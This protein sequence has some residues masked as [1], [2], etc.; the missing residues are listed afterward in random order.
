MRKRH[1]S[2]GF[3]IVEAV[4]VLGIIAA[5]AGIT[6]PVT[7]SYLNAKKDQDAI[8]RASMLDVQKSRYL[9]EQG[10][11]ALTAWSAAGDDQSRYN[12]VRTYLVSPPVNLGVGTD[13]ASYS[14]QGYKITL[15]GLNDPCTVTKLSTNTAIY[16]NSGTG[17]SYLISLSPNSTTMGTVLGGGTYQANDQVTVQA[18]PFVGYSFLQW[19]EGSTVVSTDAS[20]TFTVTAARTLVANFGASSAGVYALTVLRNN[21]L[22]GTVSP[23]SGSYAS[24]SPVSLTANPN[25]SWAFASWSGDIG[26][27]N[28]SSASITLTMDHDRTVQANFVRTTVTLSL[29]VNNAAYG[30]VAGGGT[31]PAG[32]STTV[33]A[34]AFPGFAFVNWVDA[35]NN[36]VSVA[37]AYTLTV[38]ANTTLT[39]VFA[40][41]PATGVTPGT[42]GTAAA[43]PQFT[44]DAQGRLLG[45]QNTAINIPSSAVNGLGTMAS[46]NSNGVSVTGGSISGVN[47]SSAT[48]TGGTVTGATINATAV[49]S[50]NPSTGH[51]TSVTADGIAGT[52]NRVVAADTNGNLTRTTL[53]PAN[54]GGN[55]V[56][57]T[58]DT[59]S[60]SLT[61]TNGGKFI[62]DT[63]GAT[64]EYRDGSGN[65]K[66]QL[67]RNPDDSFNLYANGAGK[68]VFAYAPGTSTFNF[69]Q[70][71]GIGNGSADH[72]LTVSGDDIATDNGY[73]L[74]IRD[75]SGTARQALFWDSSNIA[76]L[77]NNA[78]GVGG[79]IEIDTMPGG[80]PSVAI[81]ANGN[82]GIGT[83]TPSLPL[84]VERNGGTG[85]VALFRSSSSVPAA[86]LGTYPSGKG[87]IQGL[88]AT[89]NYPDNLL[90]EPYGGNVGI[91]TTNPSQLLTVGSGAA[92]TT[93]VLINGNSSNYT[94]TTIQSAGTEKWFTGMPGS[95]DY[96]IRNRGATNVVTVQD[97][98]GNVGIGT[99]S[100]GYK[101]DV[102]KATGGTALRVIGPALAT[103]NDVG[104]D[105]ALTNAVTA[106]YGRLSVQAQ[107]GSTGNESGG[108]LF[109]T[110]SS[111]TLAERMRIDSAGNV[112]IGRP[113][114]K[115]NLDVSGT[116]AP[117]IFV[118]STYYPNSY[119]TQLGVQPSA[120]GVL[121]LG[122]NGTNEIRFGASAPG[123]YG[124]VYV[125]NTADYAA[126]ANGTL[127][128][129][130]AANGNVT[131]P[132]TL[133]AGA[134]T[135]AG[136]SSDSRY[137]LKSGD[138]MTGA[139]TVNGDITAKAD[140]G[141]QAFRA[142]GRSGDNY[143]WAP[144]AFTNDGSAY[145]GGMYYLPTGVTVAAGSGLTG[146]MH[147]A[148]DGSTM[149]YGNLTAN[150]DLKTNATLRVSGLSFV[151]SGDSYLQSYSGS[152]SV[153]GYRL[154]RADGNAWGSFYADNGGIGILDGSGN[155]AVRSTGSVN[156]LATSIDF[157]TGATGRLSLNSGGLD[158][159]IAN[160]HINASSYFIA[161]GGAYFGGGPVYT[162][163]A[164]QARGGLHN[165][166]GANLLLQ[167]GTSGVTEV[168][169]T[170]QV[171]GAITVGGQNTDSRYVVNAINADN[172]D[173]NTVGN[174]SSNIK[175]G[176]IG[177]SPNRPS[178]Y[179]YPYGTVLSFY[180]TAGVGQAQIYISHAGNDLCFRGG[181]NSA[182]W[183]TWNKVLSD[184]NYTS[185]APSLTGAGASGTWGINITGN[186]ATT[187][188]RTFSN[189]RTDGVNRGSYGTMSV[190]GTASGWAGIDFT[191][192]NATFMVRSDGY[193]GLYKNDNA[194]VWGFDGSGSLASGTVPW[195]SISGRP[196]I[197]GS[198]NY[199]GQ[200]GQPTWLWG[201]NDG[202]NMYVWNPSNFVVSNVT[203]LAGIW[204]GLNYFRS[205]KGSGSYVG[206]QATYSL[207][208]F[209]SDGGAAGMS[210]HRNGA[211]AVNFGL[212]PD[213][214]LRIGGWSAAA[215]LWQ[216]DMSGHE[217]LA[218]GLN[219]AGGDL[220]FG[221]ANPSISASS[222]FVAPGGAYFNSGTVYMEAALQARGGLHN[223]SGSN[224]VL[225]GGTSGNTQVTGA[226]Y[227]GGQTQSSS[228]NST[229][230]RRFK[231][232][233]RTL[234]SSAVLAKV[235]K[236]R[237]VAY[238]WIKGYGKG[239]HD[240][241]FIAEE[242]ADLF[243]EVVGRDENGLVNSLDYGRLTT[244]AIGA[245][246]ALKQ[247]NDTIRQALDAQE[248]RLRAVENRANHSWWLILLAAGVFGTAGVIAGYTWR[249]SRKPRVF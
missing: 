123:G 195:T 33:T 66:Y 135:V 70:N 173:F 155:W 69:L 64:L 19:M 188:Q 243:P 219:L 90:V 34:T 108:L 232:N 238:D 42:Y 67:Y 159:N 84:A 242:V 152:N 175:S 170:L 82:V 203:S 63:T 141:A 18:Q 239:G 39:A 48:L 158:F 115:A 169:G 87:F 162:E 134:L 2:L 105:L 149:A 78:L 32:T 80:S 150:G 35:G 154:L 30:S 163:A 51:F 126:P 50:T 197:A 40:Q 151:S 92:Q 96:I 99:A 249:I 36:V 71:V 225:S 103:T 60:G 22:A 98:T 91:G 118:S 95:V 166:T 230:S 29:A 44:V 8:N 27:A 187:S 236:L 58:G 89:V 93:V 9:T 136:Q 228:F 111:G 179:S 167:G 245:I 165:D 100:P 28:A 3:T 186:S 104:I 7:L 101:L 113:D 85:F 6:I 192:V 171:D 73:G 193:S 194:W 234:D 146:A 202:S 223:D 43:V 128:M 81:L 38:N 45:A 74:R 237:P 161:P 174:Q 56:L 157:F 17:T 247:K 140:S 200:G 198:W 117:A 116:P 138:T 20:F 127:A 61:V 229:S 11:T 53:D 14:P 65:V 109:S 196:S 54:I 147:W 137:V 79:T 83:T 241:G 248:T 23:G 189:V 204:D 191:A 201:T 211:Y 97:G 5:L 181:W 208:A 76:H 143:A 216:L 112:G 218:N 52:G 207:M 25:P 176:Y 49:G 21:T 57:K 199:S 86:T 206:G 130:F 31:I 62:I 46:Q 125:N 222:Y 235:D 139:L 110:V 106:T 177:S 4:I 16:P 214:V 172:F 75:T 37:N 107:N 59:M 244:V 190:A 168:T 55:Y 160:P 153:G 227:V 26:T 1:F 209:S 119:H 246:K 184:Q 129:S 131:V 215:N 68:G 217:T 145:M 164:I 180:P 205:N 226:L 15:N 224:L 213:N 178:S 12:L 231:D 210:F 240:L 94:G 156:G 212:D 182:S 142:Y 133:T 10:S 183:Q 88:D 148:P 102:N 47:L 13:T 221:K 132:N 185:Y 220:S 41:A 124:N 72:K 120:Q 114:P 144:L 121:V 233:I 77:R 122:N 24:G